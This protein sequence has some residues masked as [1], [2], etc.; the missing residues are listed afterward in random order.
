MPV[1]RV[2]IV[3]H[4]ETDYNVEH[5]WQGHLD[6]PLNHNGQHQAQLLAHYLR[7]E[8][9]DCI[10]ASDLKRAYATAQTIAQSKGLTVI[11]DARLREINLGVFQGMTNMQIQEAYPEDKL[12]WDTNNEFAPLKGE[13]R[14]QVQ[15]RAYEAWQDITNQEN[16]NTV[17]LVAHGGTIRMLLEKVL[18]KRTE[19]IKL[20]NTSVSIIE[21]AEDMTWIPTALNITP[22]I[23]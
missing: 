5:R 19:R 4:G 14:Y 10:F 1:Q 9:I 3:R 20:H 18:P 13:S 12:Q 21:R 16:I 17:L 15:N 6:V 11:A 2:F 22:H 23:P 7:D 8:E